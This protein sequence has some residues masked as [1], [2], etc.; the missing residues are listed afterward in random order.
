MIMLDCDQSYLTA[1]KAYI[2]NICNGCGAKGSVNV[3]DTI[4]GLSITRACDIHDWDYYHGMTPEDKRKADSRFI[5]N[6]FAL[7]ES[8]SSFVGKMLKPLRRRR[9]LKYYEAVVAFGEK[10]FYKGKV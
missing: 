4:W 10:H 6:M 9:A 5:S 1:D 7:I 8:D 3:P 2:D